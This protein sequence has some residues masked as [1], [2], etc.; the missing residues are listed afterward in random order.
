MI[1]DVSIRMDE[2]RCKFSL[3]SAPASWKFWSGSYTQ[4]LSAFGKYH[5]QGN[6]YYW[7]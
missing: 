6:K 2:N 5:S 4:L 1:L 7:K 3:P